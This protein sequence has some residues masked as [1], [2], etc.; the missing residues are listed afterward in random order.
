MKDIFPLSE[1]YVTTL[2]IRDRSIQGISE[3]FILG[4]KRYHTLHLN[5]GS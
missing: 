2:G 5:F 4:L 3:L 1:T